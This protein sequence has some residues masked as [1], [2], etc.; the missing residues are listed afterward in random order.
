MGMD[1]DTDTDTDMDMDMD[2][3][4][5]TGRGKGGGR[6]CLQNCSPK[7]C[8]SLPQALED[9]V[10]PMDR[11]VDLSLDS[12]KAS[13][14]QDRRPYQTPK[15]APSTHLSHHPSLP[16]ASLSPNHPPGEKIPPIRP[17]HPPS[18]GFASNPPYGAK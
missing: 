11:K 14:G 1:M 2:M 16:T 6:I 3:D 10:D 9:R 18:L 5:A 7:R 17:P 4:T 12:P 13:T 8:I 15:Q